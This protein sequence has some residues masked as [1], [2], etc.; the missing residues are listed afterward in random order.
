[1]IDTPDKIQWHPAFYAATELELHENIEQLEFMTEYNLSKEPIRI[2][3]LI[4]NKEERGKKI[5]NEIGHMMKMYNVI[6]YK[7]P[8]DNLTIDDFYKT[9][10]YACLYKGYGKCVD[11]IPVDELTISI[12]REKHPKKMFLTLK[13][14]GHKIEERYPGIYYIHG[15]PFSAQVVVIKQL[16]RTEHKSLRVLSAKADKE[17]VKEFLHDV[18][19]CDP[20]DKSNMDAV[21]QAS[22]KANYELYEEIRREST[23]C[24]ALREL[25]KD[26]IEKDVNAAKKIAI[27]EGR[28]EGRAEGEA[29]LIRNMNKNGML[30]EQISAATGKDIEAVKTILAGKELELV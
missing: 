4:I 3:L 6:E 19:A 9:V 5:K 11:Q 20:R 1:M 21:L 17:D 12:F 13:K 7:S 14:Y 2:D 23:M 16:N 15:L 8:E 26:E 29:I 22:V 10:G 24:E 27:A 28:A 30:P 18:E 25:M